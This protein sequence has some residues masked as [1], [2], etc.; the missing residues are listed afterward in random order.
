MMSCMMTFTSLPVGILA[1][2]EPV[3]PET[4]EETVAE[5]VNDKT[6]EP[7]TENDQTDF[8]LQE[9]TDVLNNETDE[10]VTEEEQS[11]E[12]EAVIELQ[13]NNTVSEPE[14][15]IQNAEADTETEELIE[16]TVSV[17]ES[18]NLSAG[19]VF[20]TRGG[21]TYF[22]S[23]GEMQIGYREINGDIYF[24][25]SNGVMQ[26]G[27]VYFK[28][29]PDGYWQYFNSNGAAA[30]GWKKRNGNWYYLIRG[31][32]AVYNEVK[33]ID[34]KIYGF[35]SEGVMLTGWQK[36]SGKWYFFKSN[37]AAE[38]GWKKWKGK[39]YFMD[40]SSA[41]MFT[42]LKTIDGRKYAFNSSGAMLTGWRQYS[43][44]WY[45]FK[46]NGAAEKGWKKW[47][48][49]WYF[50]DRSSAV[51]VTGVKTIDGKIYGFNSSGAMLYGW[52]K[53]SGKWYFFKS[54]GA[55]E[56]G[57]KKW[58]GSW[59]FLD[60]STAVMAT[61]TKT[62]DGKTYRFNSSGQWINESIPTQFNSYYDVIKAYQNKY[63]EAKLVNNN[64]T[65]LWYA[66]LVDFDGYN[67]P[68][69]VIGVNSS[70]G[71]DVFV[72][73][74][75]SGKVRQIGHPKIYGG[76]GGYPSSIRYYR[77]TKWGDTY[78]AGY[79]NVVNGSD[80]RTYEVTYM[81]GIY[82]DDGQRV[83]MLLEETWRDKYTGKV[84]NKIGYTSGNYERIGMYFTSRKW[85]ESKY[86][87][88]E[89]KLYDLNLLNNTIARVKNMQ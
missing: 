27:W 58:K 11:T 63:G 6:D 43:G 15:E 82:A 39:W 65:G 17:Q 51:M 80:G 23:N 72:F 21:K 42:G 2:E 34:G 4:T 46:S 67:G 86:L 10:S 87:N 24:F 35:N 48:G 36:F 61:G 20:V 52:Q 74:K 38:K 76:E 26:K 31:T 54:N 88:G 28:S 56:K 1:E 71:E 83:F 13:D 50:M 47:N 29:Y 70:S 5:E 37:G 89:N 41:V 18:E 40:R 75:V 19:D 9:E 57:W 49:K 68:E 30:N 22:Y 85:A 14:D 7:E 16:D 64:Y 78:V 53:F 81:Y 32:M 3:Q 55:A 33:N 60:R 62:I 66:E 59:Y 84:I 25:D 12:T 77:D 79:D 73:G 8:E 45:F 69:L 44:K